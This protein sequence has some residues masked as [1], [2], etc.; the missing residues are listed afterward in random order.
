M[1][2]L[3]QDTL[4]KGG[5]YRIEKI[6]NR[7]DF[8][9]VYLSD[10]FGSERNVEITEFFM[11]DI[12]G[13]DEKNNVTYDSD[14]VV[15]M[16]DRFKSDAMDRV[17]HGILEVFEENNTVY[18]VKYEGEGALE[19]V[20]DSQP[21]KNESK[22]PSLISK[23]KWPL[24]VVVALGACAFFLTRPNSAPKTDIT[25][26]PKV[27]NVGKKTDKVS[28]I[29]K[30]SAAF[31]PIMEKMN[32][33]RKDANA[34]PGV[35]AAKVISDLSNLKDE[36]EKTKAKLSADEQARFHKEFQEIIDIVKKRS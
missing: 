20:N 25:V 16:R 29:E 33:I 34:V 12:C 27:E 4:L 31:A 7:T 11:K 6:L 18:Y 24:I 32:K 30:E 21:N 19:I 10:K 28:T 1:Q 22:K 35:S 26:K 8:E 14:D 13:R 9:I 36:F 23:L 5:A 2:A 3:Q 17:N 15:T